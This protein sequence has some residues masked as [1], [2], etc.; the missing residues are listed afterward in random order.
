M[1]IIRY[2]D[3][4]DGMEVEEK[5]KDD[6]YYSFAARVP[7]LTQAQNAWKVIA[8]GAWLERIKK[9]F[10]GLPLMET[11]AYPSTIAWYGDD[12]KFI[13]GNIADVCSAYFQFW[14]GEKASARPERHWCSQLAQIQALAKNWKLNELQLAVA[15]QNVLDQTKEDDNGSQQTNTTKDA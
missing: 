1:L 9:H 7:E 15:I 2:K 14:I 12:A 8:S 3:P 6:A 10:S 5:V 13:A 11:G 4:R